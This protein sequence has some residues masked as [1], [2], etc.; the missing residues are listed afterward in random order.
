MS[1][2]WTWDVPYFLPYDDEAPVPVAPMVLYRYYDDQGRLLYVGITNSFK[3]RNAKHAAAS[4]WIIF[5]TRSTT[6]SFPA[7]RDAEEA[8]RSA[9]WSE[10]PLFNS[11]RNRTPWAR[12]RLSV[13]LVE[14]GRLDLLP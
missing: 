13:Y 11:Q 2:P 5:A 7:R 6:E 4:P 3:E 1:L 14:R 10:R 12:Q 8:E 9:I